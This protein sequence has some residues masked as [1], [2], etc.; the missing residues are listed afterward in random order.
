MHLKDMTEIVHFKGDGGTADQWMELFPK[1]TDAGSGVLDL[2]AILG[3][4]KKNGVEHFYLERDLA[5]DP[6]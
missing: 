6:G 1:M 2:P 5:A 4:A 3:A